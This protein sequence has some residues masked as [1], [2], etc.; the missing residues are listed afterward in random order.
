[1]LSKDHNIFGLPLKKDEDFVKYTGRDVEVRLYKPINGTKM[2]EGALVGLL[3][4]N[5]VIKDEKD[6]QLSFDKKD[7]SVVKLA[8]KF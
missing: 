2:F 1:M 4:N 5:I 6:Q 3:D 7:V 8:V